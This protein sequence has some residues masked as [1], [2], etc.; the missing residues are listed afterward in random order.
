MC[1][2]LRPIKTEQTDLLDAPSV[3]DAKWTRRGD[4][5][6]IFRGDVETD[7]GCCA[8]GELIVSWPGGH[9]VLGSFDRDI[10]SV[11]WS[12]RG[13]WL[14]VSSAPPVHNWAD[15]GPHTI[16]LFPAD[17]QASHDVQFGCDSC[18]FLAAAFSPDDTQLAVTY[19]RVNETGTAADELIAVADVATGT[20]VVLDVGPTSLSP[21]GWRDDRTILALDDGR[22]LLAIPVDAP[23]NFSVVAELPLQLGVEAWSPDRSRVAYVRQTTNPP[24]G[25]ELV[26]TD[27][28]VLDVATGTTRH[29]VR[30]V[31]IAA[32]FIWAPDN[33][34]FAYTTSVNQDDPSHGEIL[35][36]AD[37]LEGEPVSIAIGLG[38]IAWRPVWH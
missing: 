22:R 18:A 2:L 20:S 27:V 31:D 37:A 3:P 6:A 19:W 23:A 21:L 12:N 1:S 36:V 26:S 13:A 25:G 9:A 17:G 5:F 38:P 34:T 14:A 24:A 10:G 15:V 11:V 32:P 4:V 7:D 29:V 16:S 35:K 30:E 28:F 33:R 8:P